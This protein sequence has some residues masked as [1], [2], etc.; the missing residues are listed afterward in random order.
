MDSQPYT[1]PDP[2]VYSQPPPLPPPPQTHPPNVLQIVS[3]SGEPKHFY[4]KKYFL[5]ILL[6]V[7]IFLDVISIF[8]VN[9]SLAFFM[10]L[11]KTGTGEHSEEEIKGIQ[12]LIV[13]LLIFYLVLAVLVQAIFFFGIAHHNLCVVTVFVVFACLG[14]FVDV[15]KLLTGNGALLEAILT[16]FIAVVAYLFMKDLRTMRDGQLQRGGP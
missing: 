11:I 3:G 8:F 10:T 4:A 16:I 12:T 6:A 13:L 7:S 9:A 15:A 5:M 14:S 1:I 2:G